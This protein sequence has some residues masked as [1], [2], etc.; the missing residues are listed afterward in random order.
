MIYYAQEKDELKSNHVVLIF[1]ILSLF[2][3]L[4]SEEVAIATTYN[5]VKI[6]GLS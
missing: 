1:L 3:K 2:M 4:S 5:A 6:F